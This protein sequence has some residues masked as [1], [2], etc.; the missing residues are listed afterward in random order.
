MIPDAQNVASS[1][2]F[3]DAAPHLLGVLP[4]ARALDDVVARLQQEHALQ[5]EELL[6][7]SDPLYALGQSRRDAGPARERRLPHTMPS[8]Q[9]V[10]FQ[11]VGV[12][13]ELLLTNKT[14]EQLTS[15]LLTG[16][17]VGIVM[18]ALGFCGVV[19]GGIGVLLDM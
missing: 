14:E 10:M 9:L 18:A 1:G 15:K 4:D 16:F 6:C 11:A 17:V 2:T 8:S 12:N 7:P 13:G 5:A 19:A 3:N